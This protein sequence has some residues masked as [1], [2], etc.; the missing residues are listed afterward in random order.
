MARILVVDDEPVIHVVIR[1]VLASEGHEILVASSVAEGRSLIAQARELDVAF[2]DK[3]LPDGSGLELGRALSTAHP[4][5]PW[6]LMTAL[7]TLESAVEAM[8]IGAY[9]YLQ[10]PF[11]DVQKLVTLTQNATGHARIR[12]ERDS[13]LE[14]LLESEARYSRALTGA[15]VGIWDWDLLGGTVFYS[16]RWMAMVGVHSGVLSRPEDWLDHVHAEDVERLRTA[17]SR[18]LEGA[19]PHFEAEYRIYHQQRASYRWMLARGQCVRDAGGLPL[20]IAGSQTD[21]H[22]RKL[23]EEQLLHDATHDGL[24]GLPNRTVLA[25]RTGRLIERAK[26]HADYQ[27]AM[28]YV[29]LDRFK[30]VNDGLGHSSGDEL[31][32]AVARRLEGCVRTG[33]TVTRVG[34]DEF[35]IL[36]DGVLGAEGA[37]IVAR[38]ILAELARAFPLSRH[39]VFSGAAIGIALGSAAY[40]TPEELQRDADTAM[41]RAKAQGGGTFAVFDQRMHRRAVEL[42]QLH[43]TLR[44]ALERQELRVHYQPIVQ[45]G[46]RR[47]V[48]F[49]ALLRWQ[50]PER[51]MVSPGEFI[52]VAEETGLI[53]PIGEWILEQACRQLAAWQGRFTREQPLTMSVNLSSKQLRQPG[54]VELVGRLLEEH[55]LDPSCVGIELTE[56]ILMESIEHSARMLAALK[57]LRVQLHLDDFGTGFSSLSYLHRFPIDKLKID[58]SFVHGLVGQDNH[59]E[60]V[61]AIVTLARALDMAVVAEGVET[62]EQLA[63]LT[64]LG[65]HYGQGYLFARPAPPEA[66]VALLEAEPRSAPHA[67]AKKPGKK[68]AAKP[69]PKVARR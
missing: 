20:R 3:N 33:D 61:R 4:H 27:F 55:R 8:Q 15:S 39:Q 44:L 25:D 29:D 28:L 52:P 5:T 41:Y 62:E 12:K 60:I 57:E 14:R 63:A 32:V 13:L 17:L 30:L 1:E 67:L 11:S 47:I 9:D 21:I 22:D 51:G 23:A 43:N 45:V 6:I 18:H 38:R 50:H 68:P 66:I 64:E 37:V 59:H 16:P 35:V 7:A 48:G 53:L 10:K 58:R 2:L 42:L 69:R 49:E 31:L 34:G 56:S 24:T 65:C 40:A 26:R 46:S 19:E 54:L 36:L